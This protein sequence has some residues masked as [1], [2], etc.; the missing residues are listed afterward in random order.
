MSK[1]TRDV[2]R[3]PNDQS[4]NMNKEDKVILDYKINICEHTWV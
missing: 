1:D 4:N 2:E 3:T